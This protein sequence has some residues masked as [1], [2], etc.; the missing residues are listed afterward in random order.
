MRLGAQVGLV[1][2][3]WKMFCLDGNAV[4]NDD[5]SAGGATTG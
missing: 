3:G 2:G 5:L 1:A 4:F